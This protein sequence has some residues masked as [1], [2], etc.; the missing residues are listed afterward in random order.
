MVITKLSEKVLHAVTGGK[1]LFQ[2]LESR[3]L[4]NII[5]TKKADTRWDCAGP[6]SQHIASAHCQAYNGCSTTTWG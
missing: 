1:K 3:G 2:M 5:P 6:E 4:T